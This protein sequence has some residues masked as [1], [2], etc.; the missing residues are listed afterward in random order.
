MGFWRTLTGKLRQW[1]LSRLPPRDYAEY[2]KRKGVF[3]AMG[4]N[5]AISPHASIHDMAFIQLGSNVRL[6]N[7]SL[8][9]HDGSVNMINQ[10]LGTSFDAVGPIII[11]DDVFV[12]HQAIILPNVRIGS[13]VIIAAGAVVASDIPSNSVAAGVPARVVRSFDEHVERVRRKN[14]GLPWLEQRA[15]GRDYDPAMEKRLRS[16]RAEYFLG[17]RDREETAASNA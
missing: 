7:C 17:A 6:S 11:G 9:G 1:W 14:E 3:H 2:L 16:V 10:A 13:R 4:E 5:C 15:K 8:F 12:G